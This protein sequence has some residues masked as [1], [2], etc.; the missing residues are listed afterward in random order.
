MGRSQTSVQKRIREKL[1]AEKRLLKQQ[2][3]A[4]KGFQDEVTESPAGDHDIDPDIAH[5]K[6]GPQKPIWERDGFKEQFDEG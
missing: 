2:R 4:Q 6:P 3:K 1:K 5:I